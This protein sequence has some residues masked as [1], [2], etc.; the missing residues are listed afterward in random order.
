MNWNHVVIDSIKVADGRFVESKSIGDVGLS[1]SENGK[2][3][4][5]FLKDVSYV[6]GLSSNLVSVGQLSKAGFKIIFNGDTCEILQGNRI[7]LTSYNK[8]GLYPIKTV[9]TSN[10][11]SNEHIQTNCIHTWHSRLGHR[12]SNDIK[13]MISNGCIDGI[14]LKGCNCPRQDVC[15]ICCEGKMCKQK[16]TKI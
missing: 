16:F 7:I 8:N 14:K 3:S 5:I 13:K 9:S 11:V 10:F 6:P 15:R 4:T 12:D 1:L 2:S